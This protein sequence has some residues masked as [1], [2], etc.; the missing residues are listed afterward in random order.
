MLLTLNIEARYG[1]DGYGQ[2]MRSLFQF[3]QQYV[4]ILMIRTF[5]K[6]KIHRATVTEVDLNYEGSLGI[7]ADLMKAANI[8]PYEM[9]Q[10][11]SLSSG[12]RFDTYAIEEA[13]GSGTIALK[14][15]AARKGAPGD[16]IIITCFTTMD[17]KHAEGF[18]PSII[19]MD[20]NNKI[21]EDR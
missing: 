10:V 6:S 20:Q 1:P 13:A 4:V 11:Y 18:E 16:L 5:L 14:G 15:A 7:D 9:V 21:K 17:D 12:E 8:L 19:L 2:G 3:N